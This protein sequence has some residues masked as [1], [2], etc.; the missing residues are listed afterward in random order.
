[1]KLYELAAEYR[2]DVAKLQDCDMPPEVVMDTIEG[3]QGDLTEKI[4]AVLIISMEIEAEADLRAVHAKRMAESSKAMAQRA[5]GLRSYAQIA[6]QNC[7]LSLPLKYPEFNVN[8]QKNPLSC[9]VSSA[10]LLPSDM[11]TVEVAFALASNA[12]NLTADDL[13]AKLALA[14][15]NISAIQI[16]VKPDKKAV[17][18]A[19]KE[20]DAI[21]AAKAPDQA[22]DK[23][24]G[25]SLNPVGYRVTVK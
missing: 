1:M 21:N 20:I 11:K 8:L 6:I 10:E 9:E 22:H 3:M 18:A 12:N 15:I 7:G 23:L 4:K 13:I 16:S 24:P 19:L 5:E 14:G 2:N 25:A 17:L